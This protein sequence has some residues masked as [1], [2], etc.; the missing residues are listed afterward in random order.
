M[1]IDLS[2]RG[3]LDEPIPFGSAQL[4]PGTEEPNDSGM[5]LTRALFHVYPDSMAS[6]VILKLASRREECVP[7][8]DINIFVRGVKRR[9]PIHDDLA[10]WNQKLHADVKQ[11]SLSMPQSGKLDQH[12]TA[13]NPRKKTREPHYFL[14]DPGD[15][16]FRAW[17]FPEDYVYRDC[18]GVHFKSFSLQNLGKSGTW[19]KP[20]NFHLRYG[21]SPD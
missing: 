16:R 19:P 6:S 18:D 10:F 11:V 13:D 9:V 8:R 12:S 5:R 20:C 2:T 14:F 3:V 4:A 1:E 7:N 15:D 21:A 17:Q